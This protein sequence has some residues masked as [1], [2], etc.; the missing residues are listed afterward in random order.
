MAASPP[1]RQ[2]FGLVLLTAV[3]AL[4]MVLGLVA[5]V[6]AIERQ[7]SEIEK[8]AQRIFDVAMPMVFEATRMIRAL[9]HLARDGESILW[10][11][12]ATERKQRRLRL[13]SILDDA[14]LQ[15]SVEHRALVTDSFAVLDQN[16][17]DLSVRGPA[18]RAEALAR[19][20]PLKQGLINASEGVGAQVST[21]ASDE[22]DSIV[23]TSE[24]AG[25]V[26]VVA[27]ISL[28]LATILISFL[29][30]WAVTR[31]VVRLAQALK[32][33][34]EGQALTTDTV[35]IHELEVLNDAAVD[36]ARAHTEL[37]TTRSQ[38][39]HLAHTDALT[40]LANRRML[41]QRG[42]EAFQRAR[43]Y[44]EELAIVAF[45]IDHFKAINDRYSHDGGDAV[46]RALG[47]YLLA[48]SRNA[49]LPPAR[50][51][52]EEFTLLLPHA[53]LDKA[54]DAAERLRLGLGQLDV[55]VP[56]G[57]HVH[58]SASFGVSICR[59]DD[60]DIQAA[61][62]RADVALYEAKQ[63]GRNRVAA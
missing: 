48:T 47:A 28:T 41:E 57:E 40:G 31:P 21:A 49:D 12:D 8:K 51:G 6:I 50:V 27:G 30:Y 24:A 61:L 23:A 37:E 25:H 7:Q 33:V 58:F 32:R 9:E 60:A 53:T 63:A 22:A 15:G 11:E 34:R 26:V 45:D 52:G 1:T 13:Q 29:L 59:P 2:R 10:I 54:K 4:V 14:V 36:L 62:H 19:W 56:G 55:I 43:R 5:A 39:E 38:L 46:L 42:K 18:G 44:G 20:Q 17:A 3:V 35:Y 16:L